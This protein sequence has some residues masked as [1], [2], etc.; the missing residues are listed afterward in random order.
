MKKK[1]PAGVIVIAVFHFIFSACGIGGGILQLSGAAKGLQQLGAQGN[2]KQ[3]ELQDKMMRAMN[4][5]PGYHELEVA[6]GIISSIFGL[7]LVICGIGLLKLQPWAR[8]GSIAYAVLAILWQ[9]FSI[10]F[11]FAFIMPGINKAIEEAA[12]GNR[13][14]AQAMSIGGATGGAIGGMCGMIY[15][16][17][18][19]IVM[20]LPGVARAFKSGSARVDE[21]RLREDDGYS[22]YERERY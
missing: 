1:V 3:A 5:V 13:Q 15:P 9:L 11:T 17:A 2:P 19:I 6:S 8:Y 10:V 16:I 14:L 4:N 22:D 21:E 18:V 20:L 12:G 7:L